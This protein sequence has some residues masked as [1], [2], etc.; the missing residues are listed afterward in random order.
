MKQQNYL[1]LRKTLIALLGVGSII[2][3]ICYAHGIRTH[4]YECVIKSIDTDK[5]LLSLD[6]D[7]HIYKDIPFKSIEVYK[8]KLYSCEDYVNKQAPFGSVKRRKKMVNMITSEET[9]I[10]D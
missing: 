2:N 1:K 7:F 6:A 3:L 4:I 8:G 9:F 10:F 5:K